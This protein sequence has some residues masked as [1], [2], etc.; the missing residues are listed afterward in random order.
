MVRAVEKDLWNKQEEYLKTQV[1]NV[2]LGF[3][4]KISSAF[5]W[6]S[7]Y[8]PLHIVTVMS[9]RYNMRQFSDVLMQHSS[10]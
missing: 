9:S 6:L 8:K 5:K 10:V 2:D 4:L 7:D 3:V 1:T